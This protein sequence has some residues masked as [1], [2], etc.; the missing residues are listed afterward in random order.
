MFSSTTIFAH[1]KKT[2]TNERMSMIDSMPII[3][4][5]AIRLV[6]PTIL[7]L[8]FLTFIFFFPDSN[9]IVYVTSALYLPV[10]SV[11]AHKAYRNENT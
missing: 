10:Q 4:F 6:I 7:Y 2:L 5:S 11:Y 1:H 3:S 8:Y 9:F